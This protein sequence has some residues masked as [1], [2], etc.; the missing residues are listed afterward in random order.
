MQL[1]PPWDLKW[2]HLMDDPIDLVRQ[3]VQEVL[4]SGEREREKFK[5]FFCF[6][7]H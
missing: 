6:N 4:K 5:F 7:F 3:D 2:F 1:P